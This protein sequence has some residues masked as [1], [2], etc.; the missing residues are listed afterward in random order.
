MSNI[1][2]L[3]LILSGKKTAVLI[4]CKDKKN[5]ESIR[6]MFYH[7][8]KKMKNK[9]AREDVG[10]SK[11]TYDDT[12]YV[13]LFRRQDL[14]LWELDENGIPI[15]M[16]IKPEDKD[17]ELKRIIELMEKDGRSEEEIEEEIKKYTEEEK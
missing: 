4:P 2:A 3:N 6:V 5:Q 1:A 14:V 10:I 13:K 8:K 17:P 11:L 15:K 12:F 7:L 9:N 16:E